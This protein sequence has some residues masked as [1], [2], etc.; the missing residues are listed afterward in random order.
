MKIAY[1]LFAAALLGTGT[2][3]NGRESSDSPDPAS[4]LE[5]DRSA[6]DFGRVRIDGGP[7]ETVF[8][9]VND[10][11]SEVRLLAVS[12]SCG[13]TKATAEFADGS[14]VGSFDAP[15]DGDP[16]DAGR[17]VSVGEAF[18][19]RVTFDPAAHGPDGVG[20]LMREVVLATL[21]GGQTRL[22]ITAD[23]VRG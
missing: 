10:G 8:D 14:T 4:A 22:V 19:V 6:H 13:C 9:I 12:T 16:A 5:A 17:Q 11:A 1:A 20:Q 3:D 15:I 2:C 21:D 7:V 23:V 18:Q